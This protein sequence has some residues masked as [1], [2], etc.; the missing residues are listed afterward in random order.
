[1]STNAVR[2]F[3]RIESTQAIAQHPVVRARKLAA[4]ILTAV[5]AVF[6][7]GLIAAF[8]GFA[9]FVLA[10]TLPMPMILLWGGAEV[11]RA[12]EVKP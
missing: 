3:P 5:T 4:G 7:I 11:L 9:A 10:V 1:M 12:D 2:S 8:G 6:G